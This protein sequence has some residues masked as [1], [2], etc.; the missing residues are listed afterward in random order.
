MLFKLGVNNFADRAENE[1]INGLIADLE[2]P[3]KASTFIPIKYHSMV[4]DSID[5]R[6]KG[7]ITPVRNQ[8][9]CG[10]CWAFSA[11]S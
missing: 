3:S 10:G 4:P 6:K 8:E 11:V 1:T 9:L 7:A 2:E 5:W